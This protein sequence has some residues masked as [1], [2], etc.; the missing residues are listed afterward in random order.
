MPFDELLAVYMRYRQDLAA[1]YA[2]PSWNE[3]LLERLTG[4]IARLEQALAKSQPRD[5]QTDDVLPH[6][7]RAAFSDR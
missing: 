1:A 3:G 6:F 4:E 7:V 2:A 5:E